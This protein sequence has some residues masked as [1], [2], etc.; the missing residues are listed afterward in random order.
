MAHVRTMFF[1]G[2]LSSAEDKAIKAVELGR[3][4]EVIWNITNRCNL[5]C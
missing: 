4:S 3:P 1:G 5:L 2:T